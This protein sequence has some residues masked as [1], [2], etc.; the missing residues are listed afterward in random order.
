MT[1]EQRSVAID[2]V[3]AQARRQAKDLGFEPTTDALR[4][5]TEAL[6]NFFPQ[7]D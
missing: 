2:S 1:D 5:L 3:L 6:E 4:D 7:A